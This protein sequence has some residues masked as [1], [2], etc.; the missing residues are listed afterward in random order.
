M[1]PREIKNLNDLVGLL[2][3]IFWGPPDQNQERNPQSVY[4][5]NGAGYTQRDDGIV[6]VYDGYRQ[7]GHT[8][9]AGNI[10]YIDED[11]NVESQDPDGNPVQQIAYFQPNAPS[12]YTEEPLPPAHRFEEHLPEQYAAAR[13]CPRREVVPQERPGRED[14]ISSP[15][16]APEEVEVLGEEREIPRGETSRTETPDS[17][18][19]VAPNV[20]A[21]NNTVEVAHA[22]PYTSLLPGNTVHQSGM[23]FAGLPVGESEKSYRPISRGDISVALGNN[24]TNGN[25]RFCTVTISGFRYAPSLVQAQLAAYEAQ[26]APRIAPF[27]PQIQAPVSPRTPLPGEVVEERPRPEVALSANVTNLVISDRSYVHTPRIINEAGQVGI[28]PVSHLVDG[29]EPQSDSFL[30]AQGN[31]PQFVQPFALPTPQVQIYQVYAGMSAADQHLRETSAPP[32][33]RRGDTG[34][35]HGGSRGGY[36]NQENEGEEANT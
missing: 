16:A 22:A 17:S 14:E 7:V 31:P 5:G 25:P 4:L 24:Q 33:Y 19:V 34:R 36:Q 10:H 27:A 12:N 30:A 3:Y 20:I 21:I 1:P 23:N 9:S 11:G 32:V 13:R 35:E 28:T 26:V 2:S 29:V 8:D 6:E 15:A 18:V